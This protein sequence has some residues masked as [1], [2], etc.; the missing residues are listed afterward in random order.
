M[1]MLHL[2]KAIVSCIFCG[3]LA[4][5]FLSVYVTV[6]VV[7]ALFL[8]LYFI[9]KVNW[10]GINVH[11]LT[12]LTPFRKFLISIRMWTNS[13]LISIMKSSKQLRSDT[14]RSKASGV[15]AYA[16][17]SNFTLMET[18]R[19]NTSHS[20]LNRD[21]FEYNRRNSF[22]AYS[23]SDLMHSNARSNSRS[24]QLLHQTPSRY[25]GDVSFSPKGSPWGKS[26][27]PK[28]RTHGA[29]IKTVQTVAGPL[30]ASTRFNINKNLRLVIMSCGFAFFL[31]FSPSGI[32][33]IL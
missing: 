3:M 11:G 4:I 29:G 25:S 5:Y 8:F 12:R 15:S 27:S 1:S 10:S 32:I 28:L 6:P 16:G 14:Q 18:P 7:I 13:A 26:V 24:Q 31:V 19:G 22:S 9:S 23:S 30:L 21:N 20:G 33:S 2:H 17:I